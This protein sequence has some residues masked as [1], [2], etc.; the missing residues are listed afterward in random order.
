[1]T[2]IS[3]DDK[4]ESHKVTP[5]LSPRHYKLQQKRLISTPMDKVDEPI[6]LSCNG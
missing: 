6:E 1:V 4:D 5:L 3:F 2:L